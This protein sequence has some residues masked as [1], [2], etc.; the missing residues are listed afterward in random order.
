MGFCQ[1]ARDFGDFGLQ[2]IDEKEHDVLERIVIQVRDSNLLLMIPG[3]TLEHVERISVFRGFLCLDFV[4][5][6]GNSEGN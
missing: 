5:Q 2:D 6:E 4:E 3:P 1:I